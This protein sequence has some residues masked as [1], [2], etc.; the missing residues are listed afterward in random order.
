MWIFAGRNNIFLWATGWDFSTFNT[1]HRHIGIVA[2]VQAIVHAVACTVEELAGE[3]PRP[4]SY[5]IDANVFEDLEYWDDW[6]E[7]YWYMG[8]VVRPPPPLDF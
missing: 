8:A 6:K 4:Y 2:T 7:Q 1:F 3:M 5:S